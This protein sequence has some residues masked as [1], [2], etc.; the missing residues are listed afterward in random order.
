VAF[1]GAGESGVSLFFVLSAFCLS[2]P[3]F[4]R[5]G[6]AFSTANF[7]RRRALRILPLYWTAVVLGTI[8]AA[9]V[10][11]DLLHGLPYLVFGNSLLT[12]VTPLKPFSEVWWSLATEA[13]FYM[14]LPLLPFAL[15]S[16]RGRRIGIA[17]LAL[18]LVWFAFYQCGF[19]LTGQ[20][21]MELSLS[22][23]LLGRG[24]V[25]LAGIFCAWL[26]ARHG[27]AMKHWLVERRFFR[28]GGSDA[29]LVL[30][31]VAIGSMLQWLMWYGYWKAESRGAQAWHILE[32][33]SWG[34]LLLL[35]LVAPLRTKT[36]ICNPVTAKIGLWSYSI[37]LI[38]I[39]VQMFM[40]T[41]LPVAFPVLETERPGLFVT[42]AVAVAASVALSSLTY[43]LIEKPFL[44]RKAGL[45]ARRR[46]PGLQ[47][48][49]PVEA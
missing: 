43:R 21:P 37:Y 20:I 41:R 7:F 42:L 49:S 38:H 46:M 18:Y 48:L 10:P 2:L 27:D 36:A 13:Q 23:S 33:L 22:H 16:R 29:I 47:S 26:Y 1:V 5:G 12:L 25:F 14:V 40:L 44:E 8:H 35:M 9:S 24:P 32:G 19:F 28:Q 4:V 6:R 39:P 31:I 34:A 11:A 45:G 3:V 17:T 30:V 15:A